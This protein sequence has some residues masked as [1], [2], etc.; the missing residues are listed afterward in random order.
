[1]E[2][3]RT[4][5]ILASFCLFWQFS[6]PLKDIAEAVAFSRNEGQLPLPLGLHNQYTI[7]FLFLIIEICWLNKTHFFAL[8]VFA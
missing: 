4:I 7:M 3:S 1:M 8:V 2:L 6:I 5:Y